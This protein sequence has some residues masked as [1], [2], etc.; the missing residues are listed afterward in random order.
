MRE[1][2]FNRIPRAPGG[3]LDPEAPLGAPPTLPEI[4]AIEDL[5]R[6][7]HVSRK[8]ARRKATSGQLGPWTRIGRRI[9]ITRETLMDTLAR[10]STVP[11]APRPSPSVPHPDPSIVAR[12]C[13][14]RRR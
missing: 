3:G 9:Y 4:L 10:P 8:T 5:A 13:R 14:G 2:S 7:L 6:A 1:T 12:L 11:T